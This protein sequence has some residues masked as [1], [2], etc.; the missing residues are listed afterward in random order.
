MVMMMVMVMIMAAALALFMVMVVPLMS[1]IVVVMM[2]LMLVIVAAALALFMVMAALRADDLIEK[3]FLERPT[4]LHRLEDLIAWQLGDRSR[5]KRRLIVKF[6][7]QSNTLL[8]LLRFCFICTAQNNRAGIFDLV[9]EELAE[10]LSVD[11]AL[12]YIHDRREAVELRINLF[13]HALYRLDHVGKLAHA[14][15]LDQDTVRM[16]GIHHLTQG[17]P[18]ISYK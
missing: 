15:R 16:I 11:P 14:R 2:V 18:K 8:D 6:P 13:L 12:C 7:Q 4:C 1:V 10:I 3:F 17:F 5:D 9:A